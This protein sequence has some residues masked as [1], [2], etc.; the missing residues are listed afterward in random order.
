M[1]KLSHIIRSGIIHIPHV[2]MLANS[3]RRGFF[4]T[5]SIQTILLQVITRCG[6]NPDALHFPHFCP[7]R[8]TLAGAATGWQPHF[9][10]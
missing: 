4:V 1:W 9:D 5:N 3:L 6:G 2:L 8:S 7:M 10:C